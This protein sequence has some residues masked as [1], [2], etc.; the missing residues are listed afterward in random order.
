MPTL[1]LRF[2]RDGFGGM[3]RNAPRKGSDSKSLVLEEKQF[4]RLG[5]VRDRRVDIRLVAA[6][7]QNLGSLIKSKRFRSD[8]FFR[9]STIPLAVP[10]LRERVED[11]PLMVLHLLERL[12]KELCY[13]NVEIKPEAMR[14][15]QSYSWPGNI[16]EMKNVLERA[17]LLSGNRVIGEKNLHFDETDWPEFKPESLGRTLGEVERDYISQVLDSEGGG[18]ENAAKKLGIPRSSLY[19]KL[20]Q[21]KLDR[22]PAASS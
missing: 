10:P 14:R 2:F 19:A 9:I 17:V 6:T 21:Y 1:S 8:L 12:S 20:K 16:R 5:D 3:A 11:I 13:G 22:A 4:R 18:V 15:L 7:H